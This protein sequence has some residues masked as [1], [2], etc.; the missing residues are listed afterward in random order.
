MSI[1]KVNVDSEK[2]LELVATIYDF[3]MESMQEEVNATAYGINEAKKS[4]SKKSKLLEGLIK[5]DINQYK[6]SVDKKLFTIVKKVKN[7]LKGELYV[8]VQ[9]DKMTVDEKITNAYEVERLLHEARVYQYE[10]KS[11]IALFKNEINKVNERYKKQHGG[12][13]P[14]GEIEDYS[15]RKKIQ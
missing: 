11:S 7:S 6:K 3:F 1:F 15:I 5:Y 10:L 2:E 14:K 8:W 9:E 12:K 4:L 13:E